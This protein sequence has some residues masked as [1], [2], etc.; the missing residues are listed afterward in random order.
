MRIPVINITGSTTCE[1]TV[2]NITGGLTRESTVINITGGITWEST[3][4]LM[5]MSYTGHRIFFNVIL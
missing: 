2:I 5:Y 1:S 3:V 4:V